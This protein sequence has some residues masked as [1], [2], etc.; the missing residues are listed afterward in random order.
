MLPAAIH[1]PQYR[2]WSV[3]PLGSPIS[4]RNASGHE[5]FRTHVNSPVMTSICCLRPGAHTPRFIRCSASSCI[6]ALSSR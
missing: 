6:D 4:S 5:R 3:V 2:S 1:L